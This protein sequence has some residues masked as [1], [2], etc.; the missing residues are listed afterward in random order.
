ME[1]RRGDQ[2][3]SPAGDGL[4]VGGPVIV[5]VDVGLGGIVVIAALVIVIV[6][7]IYHVLIIFNS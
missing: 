4:G 6:A 1:R 3:G 7:H 5:G 2:V